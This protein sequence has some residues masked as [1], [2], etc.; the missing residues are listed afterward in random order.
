MTAMQDKLLSTPRGA[1]G[2]S[3]NQRSRR[4]NKIVVEQLLPDLP[5]RD[6][7]HIGDRI[8]HLH[9]EPLPNWRAFINEVQSREPGAKI[10]VTVERIISGRRSD[11]RQIGNQEPTFTTMEIEIELGSAEMLRNPD[12]GQIQRDGPVF[13]LLKA[14]AT[15]VASTFAPKP[16]QIRLGNN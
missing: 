8:T 14:E 15:E 3:V 12:T 4:E 7:L 10:T 16:K 2:I 13:D 9:G 5:A 11:R 6:V 1:V